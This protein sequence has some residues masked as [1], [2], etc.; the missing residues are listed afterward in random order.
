MA[1]ISILFADTV[2]NVMYC[3]GD[4]SRKFRVMG[5]HEKI[6]WLSKR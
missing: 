6:I 2:Q 3:E 1:P 5:E 4:A